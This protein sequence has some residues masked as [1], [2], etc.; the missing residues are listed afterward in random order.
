MFP[1]TADDV[2]ETVGGGIDI[3]IV[4]LIRVPGENDFGAVAD[5]CDDG[6]DF[7]R[8]QVLGFVDDHEYDTSVYNDDV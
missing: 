3:R 5:A 7:E 2:V 8:R 1:K 6:F 4:N